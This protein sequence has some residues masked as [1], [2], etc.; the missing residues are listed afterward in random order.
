M[1]QVKFENG[2][3]VRTPIQLQNEIF[4]NK[5]N[6]SIV[7]NITKICLQR[8]RGTFIKYKSNSLRIRNRE[9]VVCKYIHVKRVKDTIRMKIHE[10]FRS[11]T[12]HDE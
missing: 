4:N 1:K 7:K 10:Y 9:G 12:R 8:A 5:Q 2:T 6:I 11:T 3:F